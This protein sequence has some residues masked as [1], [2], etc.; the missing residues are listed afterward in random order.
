MH[1]PGWPQFLASHLSPRMNAARAIGRGQ[2]MLTTKNLNF[3]HEYAQATGDH[4][5]PCAL[6]NA[7]LAAQEKRDSVRP[8]WKSSPRDVQE[9]REKETRL[10]TRERLGEASAA[11]VHLPT[12]GWQLPGVQA[13]PCPVGSS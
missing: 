9:F 8:L 11:R 5:H 3:R 4:Q 6:F 10:L 2:G 7:K 12:A 13:S 1:T